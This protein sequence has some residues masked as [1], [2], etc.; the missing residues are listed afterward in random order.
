MQNNGLGYYACSFEI[1]QLSY[2]TPA[3]IMIVCNEPCVG[4]HQIL[5]EL[6]MHDQCSILK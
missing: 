6:H 1:D 5:H 2:S 4:A 3:Y